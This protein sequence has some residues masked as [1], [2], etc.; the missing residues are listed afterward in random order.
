MKITGAPLRKTIEWISSFSGKVA[1]WC[2]LAMMLLISYDVFSRYLLNSPVLFSDEI[3]GYM[4]VFIGFIGAASALKDG[5]HISVDI[6]VARLKPKAQVRLQVI[7]SILSLA[8]LVIFCWHSWVMVYR[9]FERNVRV[10]SIL[11]TPLWIPQ[12]LISIGSVFLILQLLVEMA[13]ALR[14][15]KEK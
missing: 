3:S 9:S 12:M 2:I 11:L 14:E 6:L 4:L 15:L 5:R 7:T 13:K 8:V 1:M 10:P